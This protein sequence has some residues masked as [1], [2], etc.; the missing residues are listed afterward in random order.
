MGIRQ[1]HSTSRLAGAAAI[2]GAGLIGLGALVASQP[3][4]AGAAGFSCSISNGAPATMVQ[5]RDGRT[6]PMIRWT[7]NTF[8]GAGWTPARR[9]QEVS[10]RFETYRQQGRLNYITT[11][12]LNTLP[13]ICTAPRE[14]APCDGLLYTLKPGQ[15]PTVALTRLL[16]VRFKARGPLNESH[17]RL[18]VSM[19]ELISA[20]GSDAGNASSAAQPAGR[21]ASSTAAGVQPLW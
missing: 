10:Q 21:Q 9:C 2:A 8:D 4:Q 14:G 3:A 12:R 18:Y 19:D 20:A 11:G 16:D 17:G 7:S 5:T 6:V 13:V 1:A 15:D